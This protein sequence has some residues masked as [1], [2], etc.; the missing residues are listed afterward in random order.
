MHRTS[1]LP[2]S[3]VFVLAIVVLVAAKTFAADKPAAVAFK[4]EPSAIELTG[5]LNR[6]QLQVTDSSS[7]R[8]NDLTRRVKY[9]VEPASVLAIDSAG[10]LQPL[11]DGDATVVVTHGGETVRVPA[12]VSGFKKATTNFA[13]DIIPILSKT[14]CNQGACHASQ[15]GKRRIQA[16]VVWLRSRT[17]SSAVRAGLASATGFRLSLLSK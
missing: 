12:K 13:R 14:G 2:I 6:L 16:L 15:Y 3:F 11:T 10:R 8:V 17:G 7:E 4:I 9:T 5:R 1:S